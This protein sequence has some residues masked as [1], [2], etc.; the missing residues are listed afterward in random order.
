MK[1]LLAGYRKFR[2]E[3]WPQERCRFAEL[4]KGQRPHSLI[5]ACCDSR[6]DPMTIFG[7]RPGELFVVRNV[8]SIVP[9]TKREAGIMV[10][11]RR[12]PLRC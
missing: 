11:A 4:A 5:I 9:P 6:V 7:A 2:H 10:S 1:A 3:L 12:L 8:A